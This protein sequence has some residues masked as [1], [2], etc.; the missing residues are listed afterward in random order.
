MTTTIKITEL[1]EIGANLASSTVLPVVNMA[2]TPTTEKT[3][4]GNIANVVLAGAGG[5]YVAAAVATFANTANVAIT[6]TVANIANTA[7]T[8]HTVTTAAQPNITSVGT[9]TSLSVIGNVVGGNV[10]A[11]GL[12]RGSTVTA[13]DQL[14]TANLSSNGLATIARINVTNTANLGAVGNV[15]ITGGNSGQILSTD[16]SGHLSWVTQSGSNSIIGNI[17]FDNNIIYSLDGLYLDNSDLSHDATAAVIVPSNGGGN[18]EI[19]NTYGNVL[20]QTGSAGTFT[21]NWMF[22]YN[23]NLTLPSNTFTVNYANGDPVPLGAQ[24][25]TANGTFSTLPDF[26][27][28]VGGT[29]VRTG[30]TGEGVFFDGDAGDPYISYPVR[31]NFS[32]NGSTKVVVTV[33]MVVND[34]CSDFGLCVFE[35]NEN[36]IQPQWAWD[37][38]PTRIAAQYDCTTPYIY[39]LDDS[40]GSGWNIPNNGTYRVR[41]TY[42][43]QN[44]NS[45]KLETLTTSNTLLDTITIGGTLNTSNQYYIGFSADQDSTNLRTY[46]KNLTIAINGGN[47]YTNSLQ[48]SG[49][50]GASNEISASDGID[51]ANLTIDQYLNLEMVYNGTTYGQIEFDATDDMYITDRR[52]GGNIYLSTRDGTDSLS[53]QWTFGAD[54]N[55]TLPTNN[56]SINYANGQP[57]GGGGGNANTGNV[58]FD[59]INIIGTG[60]L[61]LQPD[62]A[63]A[64]AYL[65][66]YLTTGPDI[67]IAGNGENVILGRDDNANVLVNANGA[68][69]IQSYDYSNA[70][71]YI[72]NFGVDGST[73]FPNS[74][75]QSPIDNPLY[76]KTTTS[77]TD[78][79]QLNLNSNSVDLYAYNSNAES[80]AELYLDNSNTIAPTASIIVKRGTGDEQLWVFANNGALTL[81]GGGVQ[82]LS[83]TN[84]LITSGTSN[85]TINTYTEG[86]NGSISWEYLPDPGNANGAYSGVFLTSDNSYGGQSPQYRIELASD[87][88]NVASDHVWIFDASGNLKTAGDIVG[89]A[90]ANLTIFANAGVHDFIF[91]SDGTFYAPDNV[92]LGGTSIYIGPGANTLTGFNSAVMVASS[93]DEAFIQAVINN[94]SDNGSADWVAVGHRGDDTGGWADMGFT[95]GSFSDANYTITGRGDGYVFAQ[96]FTNAQPVLGRGGNLVLATGENGDT[97]DI[98]FGTGGFLTSNIFGRIS[99]ANNSFEL[100]RT[101]ASLTFPDGSIQTTAY[102]GGSGGNSISDGTSNVTVVA[103]DGNVVIGVDNDVASWTFATDGTIYSKSETNYKVMVTDPNGD[104]YVIEHTINDGTQDLARTSLNYDSFTINTDPANGYEWRYQGNT[105]Q[106]TEN[107]TVRGFDSNIVIQSMYGGSSGT[108]SLQSVSN[109]NDPNIF[110]TFDATTTGANIKVYNGGS[111]GGTEY[112]WKFD[113]NGNLTLPGNTFS[114]NYA[115]GTQVSLGSSS[116]AEA[117][118]AI[119]SANFNATVGSRYGVNTSSSAVTATLPAS[120]ATGGAIFFA[121]AGGAYASNNLIIDPN[122]QTIMGV[123]GNMT[124]STNNQSVGLFYNGS[125]WRIYNAG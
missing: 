2:G 16:G 106:V 110:S 91:G 98:I 14:N 63:N 97:R 39:T 11:N 105:L 123:S 74:F 43:P 33:D 125:T 34:G 53:P 30:Q 88:G 23:G 26:L 46:I 45:V 41:F 61:N 64:G 83:Q 35:D 12:V 70:Q 56:S 96:S 22:D 101:G 17:G 81:P 107:S 79:N 1:V 103:N 116:V 90:S 40:I 75:L 38:N 29:L 111:V 32:I 6:S 48:L 49:S 112:A 7:N 89:P 82:M 92:V 85:V 94:V 84:G 77:G 93:N 24:A 62:P 73:T 36:G 37:P 120:P 54:G 119:Q 121:D 80:Y 86:V 5:N 25:P 21:A 71:N 99:D 18:V 118:F 57:Y 3:V 78:E 20:I 72:W 67:H 109:N 8:A 124:V 58:T 55:L 44:L 66:I 13:L 42:D 15:T 65:N 108:A 76:I 28:F 27:Q 19:N 95:S 47:T 9:L 31:T 113:N 59:D 122:G 114:V 51:S 50:G 100:S 68:V 87:S 60:N 10:L 115:N 4:L 69:A 52:P 117:S 102:T 104:S